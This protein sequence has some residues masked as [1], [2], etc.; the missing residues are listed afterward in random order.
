MEEEEEGREK[1]WW[2]RHLRNKC[3]EL[4]LLNHTLIV[5]RVHFSPALEGS[6]VYLF[7]WTL[8]G[9]LP[10]LHVDDLHVTTGQDTLS[11]VIEA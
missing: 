3:T 10:H 1:K 6:S 8:M 2:R 9:Q 11:L 4:L 5:W 7:G